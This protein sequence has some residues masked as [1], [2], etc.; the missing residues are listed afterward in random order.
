MPLE[1]LPWVEKF[2]FSLVAM[3][4]QRAGVIF[5]FAD[6]CKRHNVDAHQWLTYVFEN[7]LDTEP[8]LQF[9]AA[10]FCFQK[11]LNVKMYVL[12]WIQ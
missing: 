2:F 1:P 9:T 5:S 10:K 3:K 12:G 6:Q 8:I 11:F 4:A 7:I